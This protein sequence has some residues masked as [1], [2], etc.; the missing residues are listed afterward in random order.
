MSSILVGEL[1]VILSE[2]PDD[3][4]VLMELHHK[5]SISKESGTA[6]WIAYING[7]KSDNNL[8]EVKL[9]N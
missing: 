9:M 1:K 8:R 6:G 3:Y 4:E 7:I 5:Y 2:Y